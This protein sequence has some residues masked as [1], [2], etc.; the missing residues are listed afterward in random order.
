MYVHVCF[1]VCLC[2]SVCVCVCVCVCILGND[3]KSRIVKEWNKH[4]KRRQLFLDDAS[5]CIKLTGK[6]AQMSIPSWNIRDVIYSMDD[7][8]PGQVYF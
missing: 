4:D 1:C 8:K 2:V 6:A 7:D 5:L 3:L